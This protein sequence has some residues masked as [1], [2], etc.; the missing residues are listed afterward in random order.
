MKATSYR[1]W[2]GHQHQSCLQTLLIKPHR[3]STGKIPLSSSRQLESYKVPC[4]DGPPASVMAADLVNK[5]YSA[6][7]PL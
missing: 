4:T 5:H 2:I 7:F 6:V 1:A 3:Y